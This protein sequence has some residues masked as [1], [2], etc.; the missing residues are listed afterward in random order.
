MSN[1]GDSL[2]KKFDTPLTIKDV[3]AAERGVLPF[4]LAQAASRSGPLLSEII[5][6]ILSDTTSSESTLSLLSEPCT[7]SGGQTPLHCAVLASQLA[8]VQTLL[9]NGASVHAR[10][11]LCHSVLFYAAKQGVGEIVIAL[12]DSGAHFGSREIEG[13]EVGLEIARAIK[14]GIEGDLE[15]WKF[16]CGEGYDQARECLKKILE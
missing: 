12:K 6:S 2:L 3:E 11:H 16:A 5:T 10:D 13:G 9:A 14:G 15:N 8:N 7:L 1:N 4:I